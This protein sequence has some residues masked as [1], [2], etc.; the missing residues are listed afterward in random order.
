MTFFFFLNFQIQDFFFFNWGYI[1]KL[2]FDIQ[3]SEELMQVAWAYTFAGKKS[4][5]MLQIIP[6]ITKNILVIN[7]QHNKH[8]QKT[9]KLII[10]WI[11]SNQKK[12]TW[13]T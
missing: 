1:Y 5:Y 3:K 13:F 10:I 4:A 12:L 11:M 9:E 8:Q 2:S 7:Q 6:F